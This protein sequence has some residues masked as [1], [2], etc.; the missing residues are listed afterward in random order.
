MES[1]YYG[2]PCD[3]PKIRPDQGEMFVFSLG[4]K[5]EINSGVFF[6]R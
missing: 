5:V 2:H 1:F 4:Q 3:P 6:K